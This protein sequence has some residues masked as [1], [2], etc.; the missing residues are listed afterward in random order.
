MQKT[1]AGR[2]F[3]AFFGFAMIFFGVATIRMGR[4]YYHNYRGDN[5]FAPFAI[6]IGIIAVV[7]YFRNR[8]PRKQS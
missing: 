1:A 6:L 3:F 5:V 8:S 7:A 2:R 4:L